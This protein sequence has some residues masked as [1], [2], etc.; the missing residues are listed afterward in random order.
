MATVLAS[1]SPP[2]E[3]LTQDSSRGGTAIGLARRHGVVAE[4]S[5][6]LMLSLAALCATTT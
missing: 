5:A 6:E 1:T 2:E 3:P 4:T